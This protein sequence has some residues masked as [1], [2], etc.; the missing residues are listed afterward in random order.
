MNR[1]N[2]KSKT[3]TS[4]DFQALFGVYALV[5]VINVMTSEASTCYIIFN[6][7]LICIQ[8]AFKTSCKSVFKTSSRRLQDTLKTSSR[9]L[10]KC[11]KFA[12]LI[13]ISKYL[14]FHF[15]TP[16]SGCLQG[17]FRTSSKTYNADF[18]QKF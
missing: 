6:I 14:L 17:P 3:E 12:R 15:T 1:I 7:L 13:K 2:P 10:R 11:A 16:F 5:Y 9:H 4:R 18:L 8:Y